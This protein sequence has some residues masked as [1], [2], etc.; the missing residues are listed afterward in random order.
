MGFFYLIKWFLSLFKKYLDQ[1]TDPRPVNHF[2]PEEIITH[3]DDDRY[4][5]YCNEQF[6]ILIKCLIFCTYNS[7][8]FWTIHYEEPSLRG[9]KDDLDDAF[10]QNSLNSMFRNNLISEILQPRLLY[11]KFIISKINENE[12]LF[13]TIDL[14]N[15]E[16]W[17]LINRIAEEL[18][19]GMKIKQRIYPVEY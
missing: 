16:R 19:T 7:N 5:K 18:L 12:W 1:Q 9:L 4:D 6:E 14:D 8:K 3:Y 2:R 15:D 13:E 11:F 17:K 10:R